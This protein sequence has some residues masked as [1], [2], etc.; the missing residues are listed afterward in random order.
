M[1][2]KNTQYDTS[3]AL[4]ELEKMKE[5]M[6]LDNELNQIQDMDILLERV[7]LEAR[8]TVNADAGSIYIREADN[9]AIKYSQ[10]NTL[11]RRLPPG[12]KLIYQFYTVPI[13]KKTISGYV[14]ATGKL[15]NIGDVYTIPDNAPYRFGTSY[16]QRAGYKTTSMLTIPLKNS[17]GN[18]LG[19]IQII[20]AQDEDGNITAFDRDDEMFVTHFANN[21]ASALQR[22]QMTRAII[23]RMIRMA[24]LRD[25]RETGA[26]V[27]RVGAY[28]VEIWERYA[29]RR[30]TTKHEIERTRDILR[31]AAMLHDVGKVA[32]S[33]LIL[34]KPGKLTDEEYETMR[35]H[36][37]SGAHLFA[38]EQSE[39]DEVAAQVALRH[40][41]NWD[42]SG[43]PGHIDV[44][45]GQPRETDEHGRAVGLKGEE[46]PI[47]GRIVAIADVYDA[48]SSKR[49]YKD[50]WKE[51]DVLHEIEKES[52][53]KFDPELVECLF[54]ILPNIRLIVNRYPDAEEAAHR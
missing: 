1:A 14:A 6:R 49:V 51:E 41:E 48:L 22:A 8:Q 29:S 39:F 12:E 45:T 28:A 15:R 26:H 43:Y 27:N 20:N 17:Q 23:L 18:V 13:D 46:I 7:L 33:D 47:W 30:G 24:E 53:K 21:A 11:Q 4:S 9:L 16:D 50:A 34:K 42:G 37:Y 3:S 36:T 40:H 32:I 2:R 25:P 54:E 35:T 5:I 52:G 44:A 38:N 10:N 31:M 19:V